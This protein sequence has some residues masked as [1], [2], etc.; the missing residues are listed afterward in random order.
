ML[1]V[2]W[3]PSNNFYY[4]F[5]P[6]LDVISAWFWKFKKKKK[7]IGQHLICWSIRG[8][9]FIQK[10]AHLHS[11]RQLR[12]NPAEDPAIL[13]LFPCVLFQPWIFSMFTFRLLIPVF[14]ANRNGR[15]RAGKAFTQ[16][17]NPLALQQYIPSPT[18]TRLRN[19]LCV[20]PCV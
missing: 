3:I 18:H 13:S 15:I 12:K 7:A 14:H 11:P 6:F 10:T 17:T 9:N 20:C 19:C 1:H 8:F 5:W 2:D 4:V 16:H